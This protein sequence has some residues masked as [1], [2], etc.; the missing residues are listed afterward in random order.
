MSIMSKANLTALSP[1]DGRYQEKTTVLSAF[2]SEQGLIKYRVKVEIY[3]LIA[4]NEALSL[5]VDYQQTS[6]QLMSL[7]DRFDDTA[8]LS[9]KAIESTTNHDVKAV[10][11]W[12]KSQL[13]LL[14]LEVLHEMVHFACTSEDINNVAYALMLKDASAQVMQPAL[15]DLMGL[16]KQFA[17]NYASVSMLARTHGQAATPTTVGKEFANFYMRLKQ[18]AKQYHSLIMP[19]KMNGAVGN[20]NAH[21]IAYPDI[22][23]EKL[24]ASVL[25]KL[26]LSHNRYTTQIEPHDGIAELSHI[27]S[28]ISSIMIDLSRDCWQYISLGYF[29]QK[30]VEGEVGSSTMPH[31][32]NPIDFENAEG[33]LG[34]AQTLCNHFANKL[35]ISRLQRDLSDSTVLRNLGVIFGYLLVAC[36]S[37]KK[38]LLKLDID[39]QCLD[40]D[41]NAHWEVL[42]EPIQMIMRA[43]GIA[44]PYEKLKSLTRGQALTEETLHQLI[45]QLDLSSKHKDKLLALTPHNYCGLAAKLSGLL[46]QDIDNS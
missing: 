38:G 24:S 44:E 14:D 9:I 22:D 25:E 28:R 42:A 29:K 1:L 31:K 17:E 19:A 30:L 21:I 27:L 10:E 2:F 20:F 40:D 18:Q 26:G 41:L 32:V 46:D 34:L 11:Y 16:L 6:K 43:E 12:I 3:W 8:A 37:L 35:P 13:K 5:T 15:D 4:L 23:W 36:Q 7:F 39:Q 33:N 45:H